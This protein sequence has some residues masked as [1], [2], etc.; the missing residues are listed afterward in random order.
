M[1]A[2][3]LTVHEP[4]FTVQDRPDGPVLGRIRLHNTPLGDLDDPTRHRLFSILE[5]K[6]QI[7]RIWFNDRPILLHNTEG[8]HI[9]ARVWA[10]PAESR[11]PGYLLLLNVEASPAD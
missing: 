9:K 7:W 11:A 4:E 8:F 1:C 2:I 5:G 10:F 6:R 3:P